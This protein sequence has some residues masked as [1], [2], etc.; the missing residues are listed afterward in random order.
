MRIVQFILIIYSLNLFAEISCDSEKKLIYRD[1]KN[2]QAAIESCELFPVDRLP[3]NHK[4][5]PVCI[6]EVG[7]F[8]RCVNRYRQALISKSHGAPVNISSAEIANAINNLGKK[9]DSIDRCQEYKSQYLFLGIL[10]AAIYIG[11][12]IMRVEIRARY[13]K[14][15]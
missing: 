1:F 7:D 3:K 11:H 8:K 9:I 10:L 14:T 12:E 15:R 13:G 6:G 5:I 4:L 2:G